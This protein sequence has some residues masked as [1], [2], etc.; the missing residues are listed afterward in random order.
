LVV[1]ETGGA[2]A[3]QLDV[4]RKLGTMVESVAGSVPHRVAVVDFDSK[5][6]LFEDFTS[7]DG[8]VRTAM[9]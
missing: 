5:P 7:D 6:E 3:R 4:F 1:V 8:E 9:N 2:G